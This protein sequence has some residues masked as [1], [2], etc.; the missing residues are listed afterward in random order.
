MAFRTAYGERN[1]VTL[2]CPEGSS[3]AK[4]SF[5]KECDINQIMAKYQKT[6]AVTHVNKHEGQYGYA[7][8][9]EFREAL[10]VVRQGQEMFNDLPSSIRNKF[11]NSPEEFLAFVQDPQNAEEMRDLGLVAA[12]PEREIVADVAPEAPVDPPAEP[13]SSPA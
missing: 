2:E 6:G 5:K 11:S 3:M 1:R 13:G 10:E 12:E 7:T 4:Q 8:D 9:I